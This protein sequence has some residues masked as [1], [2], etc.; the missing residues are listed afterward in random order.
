LN[1]SVTSLILAFEEKRK[2]LPQGDELPPGVLKMIKVYLAVKRRLQP[3]AQMADAMAT[4]S[5]V[6]RIVAQ[7]KTCRQWGTV[8][9]C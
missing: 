2:K 1:L 4:K 3:G 9:A 8:N 6:S 7:S 5:V